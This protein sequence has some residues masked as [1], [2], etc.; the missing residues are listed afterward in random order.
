MKRI[1][2]TLIV[3]FA[4]ALP[5]AAQLMAARIRPL[6]GVPM[7]LPGPVAIPRGGVKIQLPAPITPENRVRLITAPIVFAP[8][9]VGRVRKALEVEQGK[10][11]VIEKI[12][13]LF[14]GIKTMPAVVVTLPE[15]DLE[16]EIGLR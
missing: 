15:T 1:A 10:A 14:D 16:R 2:L 6:I 7:N 3:V 4:A 12:E 13:A 5:A 11:P 8:P 9:T